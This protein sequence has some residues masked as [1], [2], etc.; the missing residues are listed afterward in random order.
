MQREI[1]IVKFFGFSRVILKYFPE[2]VINQAE[3]TIGYRFNAD[4]DKGWILTQERS[5]R[6]QCLPQ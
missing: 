3:I 6:Y 5:H 1:I 4:M 2:I